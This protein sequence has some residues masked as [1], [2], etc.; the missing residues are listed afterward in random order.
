MESIG[1]ILE[2]EI[3][4]ML[5]VGELFFYIDLFSFNVSIMRLTDCVR[6]MYEGGDA[7]FPAFQATAADTGGCSRRYWL[8]TGCWALLAC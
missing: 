3:P 7:Y 8:V 2:L 6:C 4:D 1:F 5:Y